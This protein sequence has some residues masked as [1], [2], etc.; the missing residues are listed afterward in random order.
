[1]ERKALNRDLYAAAVAD[2]AA[3]E[4]GMRWAA[5]LVEILNELGLKAQLIQK[6]WSFALQIDGKNISEMFDLSP[7]EARNLLASITEEVKN[8]K[9]EWQPEFALCLTD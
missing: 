3:E 2:E 1:M 4:D 9:V 6:G 8:L 7:M 5:H